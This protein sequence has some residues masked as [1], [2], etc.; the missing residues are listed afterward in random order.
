MD[1][2]SGHIKQLISLKLLLLV[3][4][5]CFL[6][7][8]STALNLDSLWGVWNDTTQADTNRLKSIYLVIWKRYMFSQPDS[9][10]YYAGLEYELAESTGNKLWQANALNLKGITFY[11]KG[12]YEEALSYYRKS[13][14]NYE[15]IKYLKGM[16]PLY[17]NIGVIYKFWGNY[18]DALMYYQKSLKI[19][20]EMSDKNGIVLS[21]NN[22][23]A[24]YLAL[25]NYK[26]ALVYFQNSLNIS[27]EIG[28]KSGMALSYN[29]IGTT[30]Q[31]KGRFKVAMNYHQKSVKLREEIG[32]KNGMALSYNNIGENY[33]NI[34]N[35]DQA[36]SSL[37]KSLKIS[38]DLGDKKGLADS[39][40]R[41]GT[42]YKKQADHALA[43]SF[44]EKALIIAGQVGEVIQ[45][46]NIRNFLYKVYKKMGQSAKALEMHELYI[47]MR[48]SIKNDENTK[49]LAQQQ[50]KYEYEKKAT[51]DSVRNA[52]LARVKQS[53]IIA[54][55]AELNKKRVLS[56]GQYVGLFIVL[57]FIIF[58]FNRSNQSK[59]RKK[60]IES[61]TGQILESINYAKKIQDALLPAADDMKSSVGNLYIHYKSKG[62]VSGDFYWY[63]EFKSHTV[64]AC[65]DCIGQKMMGGLMS[66]M[67]MLLLDKVV[68]N[69]SLNSSEILTNLSDEII[70]VLQQEKGGSIK[71]GVGISVCLI[72]RKNKSM[73]Y[74]GARNGII[75]VSDGKAKRYRAD[76]FPVGG[77]YTRDGVPVNRNFGSHN[78]SLGVNDW[79]Y[80]YTDGFIEQLGGDKGKYM[81]YERFEDQLVQ[82]SGHESESTKNE[83][84]SAEL[85]KWRGT[86]EQHDDILVMGFQL[87]KNA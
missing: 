38:E 74:S 60:V 29:N 79:V 62:L 41:I 85:D 84:L 81:G 69:S 11:L 63:K 46:E 61:Q 27:K 23:G 54:Q 73:E 45:I 53:K 70:R 58:V 48:D 30:Y 31:D 59:K 52:E 68:K 49:A 12:N 20:E 21:Y 36:L 47:E 13:L 5:F 83:F 8:T 71:E 19:Y 32:D 34:G 76:I 28:D 57:V 1:K 17:N 33:M 43:L 67:G 51:A 35:Y 55:E 64:I 14:K 2:V 3:F 77:D 25:L 10:F 75:V 40:I 78:I 87:N 50:Y 26:E 15:E 44:G 16:S 65:V 22:I 39:Y 24:I 6:V 86:H 80:M 72:D 37:N 42:V 66:T 82:L 56:A 18:K 9:A 7:S 4:S